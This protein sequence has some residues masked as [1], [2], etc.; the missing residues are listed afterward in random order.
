MQCSPTA[1]SNISSNP[2]GISGPAADVG[3]EGCVQQVDLSSTV[4]TLDSRNICSSVPSG[5]GLCVPCV[6]APVCVCC[7][8]MPLCVCV[9]CV[10]AVCVCVCVCQQLGVNLFPGSILY[11]VDLYV[12]LCQFHAV[13][14]TLA[15]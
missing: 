4:W 10:C 6:C 7:V 1:R 12:F 9:M 5:L 8:S 14:V 15:L 13:F 11:S 2:V 3:S